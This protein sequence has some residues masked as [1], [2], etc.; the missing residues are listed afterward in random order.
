MALEDH[1]MAWFTQI[2]N[3]EHAFEFLCPREW[4]SLDETDDPSVRF[5]SVCHEKVQMCTTPETFVRLGNAGGC[6][7]MPQSAMPYKGFYIMLGRPSRE[8][9][10]RF[11]SER[12]QSQS[13]WS[14]VR[15]LQPTFNRDALL[16]VSDR[17]GLQS[18]SNG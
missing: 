16:E 3:C 15:E 14:R 7:A 18:E 1:R 2:W 9:V 4:S 11:E 5:C 6:V 12:A 10:E 17:L 13:W 8:Q